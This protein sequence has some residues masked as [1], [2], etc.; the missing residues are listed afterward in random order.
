MI[1]KT[2]VHDIVHAQFLYKLLKERFE[3]GNVNIDLDLLPNFSEHWNFIRNETYKYS[4][5][6]VLNTEYVGVGFIKQNNEL[7]IF[8]SKNYI[9]RGFGPHLITHILTMHPTPCYGRVNFNNDRSNAMFQNLGFQK[10]IFPDHYR[11]TYANSNTPRLG[12][13]T[14]SIKID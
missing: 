7:G 8:I 6:L 9:G 12:S 13:T 2:D 11:W 14:K 5:L 3:Y 1:I 4:Y 10:E